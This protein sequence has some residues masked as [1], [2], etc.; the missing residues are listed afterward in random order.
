[1]AR[2]SPLIWLILILI[3]LLPTALGRFLLDVAGS[4]MLVLLALPFLIAGAGWI[5]W[6][7]LQSRLTKCAVCGASIFTD[8]A[9]CP[10]CGSQVSNDKQSK[11]IGDQSDSSIPASS[12]TI[13]ITP[14]DID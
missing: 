1:M 12:A 4:L 7:I 3:F 11:G 8:T 9:Q 5:G 2:P 14:K 6:R 10:V 13:D